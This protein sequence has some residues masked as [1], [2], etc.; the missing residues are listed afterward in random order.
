MVFKGAWDE[1]Q[2]LMAEC[3]TLVI[4]RL[5][6]VIVCVISSDVSASDADVQRQLD[7]SQWRSERVSCAVRD[8][9]TE[10]SISDGGVEDF[11]YAGTGI[12]GR[13]SRAAKAK[14]THSDTN[15]D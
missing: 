12:P 11:A 5:T 6:Y 4:H 14:T 15:I 13:H 2:I 8:F 10:I 3:A 9:V 1:G 7:V